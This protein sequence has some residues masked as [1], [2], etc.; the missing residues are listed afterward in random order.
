MGVDI[1]ERLKPL[2]IDKRRFLKNSTDPK[3]SVGQINAYP[4]TTYAV[5]VV[6]TLAYACELLAR[7]LR[8]DNG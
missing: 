6:T 8:E 7:S 4:T 2:L 3:Y 5:Q 1:T